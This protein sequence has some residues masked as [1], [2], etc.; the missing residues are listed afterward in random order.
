MGFLEDLA[1]IIF[2]DLINK[3]QKLGSPIN[4]NTF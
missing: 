4:K 3:N 2:N 1:Q